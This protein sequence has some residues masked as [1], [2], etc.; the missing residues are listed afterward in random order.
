MAPLALIVLAAGEGTRMKSPALP[1]VLHG[2]AGRSLLGHVLTAGAPLEPAHT[3]VVVGH[4]ADEV[5]AHLRDIAPSAV[6][7]L[8]AEQHGTGHAVRLALEA[9]PADATGTVVVVPGDAPLLTPEALTALVDAHDNAAATLLTSVVDDP[10]GYGRVIRAADGSVQ[11]VVEQ[12]DADAGELAV[13]EVATSVYAFDHAALRSAVDGL[14]RDNAQG[15]EY[16]PDVVAILV[17]EQARVGAV[18]VPADQ[19]AGVNDRVQLA[20]AH[21]IYNGRLLDAHMRAGVTVIDPATTWVD[22]EVTLEPDVTLEPA[23]DLHGA[24]RIAGGAWVGPQVTLTDTTVG[25]RSRVTRATA[26]E[27]VIGADVTIGP[28]ACLRPGT[29]LSDGVHIGTYV[30]V[31]GSEVGPGS[32]VPHLTY[33]GDATIGAHSNIGAS[34]VFVNYDGVAKHRSVVGDHVRVGSDTMIVAPVE[35]GDGAY[36]AAGSVIV[37]DVPPGAMAVARGKQRNVAGWVGR[38]RAGTPAAEAAERAQSQN[39]GNS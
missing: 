17:A 32:K 9:V 20:A 4:R 16:L 24:T 2:F 8:Q 5:T 3:V 31:K 15:E 1:K 7:V 13:H 25:A 21:R 35:I 11:R 18:T 12:K 37:S 26:T 22:A 23:T 39:E 33:V 34:S 19:T 28:Y 36:T 10:T 27:A 38:K 29:R 6:P 30:E 14:S